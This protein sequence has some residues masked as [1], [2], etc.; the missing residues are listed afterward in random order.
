MRQLLHFI[1]SA[2]RYGHAYIDLDGCLLQ[3]MPM[4]G[5]MTPDE[6]LAYWMANLCVTPIVWRRLAL[7]YVLR[8]LGVRLHVWTNRSPQH[9]E[10]TRAALGRHIRLFHSTLLCGGHKLR[11]VRM[12]PCMDDQR[13]YVGHVAGDYLVKRL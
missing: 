7:L 3:R 12:G 10:V 2:R 1:R 8:L 13:K 5:G 4:P 9:G 11:V 6:A